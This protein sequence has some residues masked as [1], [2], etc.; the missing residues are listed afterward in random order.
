MEAIPKGH[1]P[2]LHAGVDKPM[3][4]TRFPL[5]QPVWSD[6]LNTRLSRRLVVLPDSKDLTLETSPKAPPQS[7]LI[8]ARIDRVSLAHDFLS[9][10]HTEAQTRFQSPPVN[11]FR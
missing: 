2:A 4:P 11:R 1:D 9:F 5:A 3:M 10:V 6:S 7:A 8:H